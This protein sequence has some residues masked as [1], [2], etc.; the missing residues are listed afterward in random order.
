MKKV[1]TILMM[2]LLATGVGWAA[3]TWQE[4]AASEL[5]TGDIV[6]IVDKTSG[7]AMSNDQG[8]SYAPV[9]TEVS[10][11]SNQTQIS[12]PLEK[13]QWE[14]TV[15]NGTYKFKVPGTS[16]YLYCTNTNNGVRVGTNSN[17]AFT[18]SNNNNGVPF[19][20]NTAT[21]RYLG[22]Y[23]EQDWRCYTSINNNIQ[24]TVLAFYKKVGTAS[25]VATPVISGT[26][27]FEGSTQ[28]SINCET[29]GAQVYYTT[30]GSDPSTSSTLYSDPFTIN[31]TTTVKAIAV[32][33]GETSN[34]A[35]KTF[36]AINTIASIAE[37]NALAT[38]ANFKYT[39]DNLVYI[40][41]N[42]NGNNHY[43]QDGLKGMLIYGSLGQS[44]TAGDVIPSGFTGTRAVYNGA[45][46]MTNPAGFGAPMRNTGLI[47]VEIAAGDV[48]LDNFG[49][50]VVLKNVAIDGTNLVVDGVNVSFHNS[51]GATVPTETEGKTFDVTGVVGA[52]NGNAQIL[53]I[54][55]TDVT[56]VTGP[57]YY[58]VGSFN[59][60]DGV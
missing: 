25:A 56:P 8:T 4:T 48:T 29:S 12:A 33:N 20:Y 40:K 59:E 51:L 44:Y 14:V 54:E 6:V 7:M 45:P 28:V 41:S 16:N 55:F 5:S 36:T 9:A 42:A 18:I 52:Y 10:F 23:S 1:L 53:P 22:V 31:A 47:P 26:T 46:E 35:T 50:F 2:A 24:A 57:E 30:D 60:N 49:R 3:D 39:T 37:F 32:L 38:G 11:I 15:T 19:L 58:L 17:N 27:P 43:V 34:V 21:S 13:I